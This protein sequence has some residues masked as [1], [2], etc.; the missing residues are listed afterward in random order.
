[1]ITS[2]AASERPRSH[3]RDLASP[4]GTAWRR[5]WATLALSG[6]LVAIVVLVAASV[7]RRDL[8]VIENS[9][10]YYAIGPWWFL[11]ATAFLVIGLASAALG[12]ALLPAN[13]PSSLLFLTAIALIVSGVA[14]IGL[15]VY[16]MDAPGPSTFIGDAHQTAGTIGGV[17]QL[18]AALAFV[19]AIRREQ[20]WR[21]LVVPGVAAFALAATGAILTQMEI[22]WPELE[23][24]LG[25]AMRLVVL[26]LLILWAAV[27]LRL[28]NT[29]AFT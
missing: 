5:R 26:P 18:V 6:M 12:L 17:A 15:V 23:I 2:K 24:P 29:T 13:Y 3:S 7:A 21:P 25:A 10:S 14:S 28:R 19:L 27:A 22:W 16:P 8:S 11:Q 9:M 4:T 1:M 20:T